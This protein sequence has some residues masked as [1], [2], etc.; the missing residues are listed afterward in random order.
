MGY[1]GSTKPRHSPE[2]REGFHVPSREKPAGEAG[3][4]ALALLKNQ[5]LEPDG[6]K[7]QDCGSL[8]NLQVH[9]LKPRS[10]LDDDSLTNLITLCAFCQ[11]WQ[12]VVGGAELNIGGVVRISQKGNEISPATP[13]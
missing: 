8:K 13:Q 4:Q 7:C 12:V 5:V 1:S 9:H 10:R 3:C 6:W 2:K 11:A